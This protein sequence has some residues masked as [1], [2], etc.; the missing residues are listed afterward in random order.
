M[1]SFTDIVIVITQS[2]YLKTTIH[3]QHQTVDTDTEVVREYYPL[4]AFFVLNISN[5]HIALRSFLAYK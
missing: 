2:V 3:S 5:E 4:V 1:I